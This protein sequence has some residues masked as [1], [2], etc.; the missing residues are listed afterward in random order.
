M[1]SISLHVLIR[2]VETSQY[3]CFSVMKIGCVAESSAC[4]GHKPLEV[5]DLPSSEGYYLSSSMGIDAS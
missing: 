4:A 1:H 5:Q 3:W 2:S